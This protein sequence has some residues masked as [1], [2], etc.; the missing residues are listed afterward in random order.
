[1]K[2]FKIKEV[3]RK[4]L[5]E[6]NSSS[7]HSITISPSN[8]EKKDNINIEIK[9]GVITIPS[10]SHSFVSQKERYND[11]LTKIQYL[12]GIPNVC[13]NFKKIKKIKDVIKKFTGAKKVIFEWEQNYIKDYKK[14]TI[15][16]SVSILDYCPVVDF[17]GGYSSDDI[18]ESS[19]TIKEFIFNPNSWL[20][21]ASDGDSLKDE[22]FRIRLPEKEGINNSNSETIIRIDFKGKF[23]IMEFITEDIPSEDS[24]STIINRSAFDYLRYLYVDPNTREVLDNSYNKSKFEFLYLSSDYSIKP[25]LFIENNKYFLVFGDLEVNHKLLNSKWG[26]DN[27]ESNNNKIKIIKDSDPKKYILFEIELI[28][29]EFGKIL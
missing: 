22:F 25:N 11:A 27:E 17:C 5:P 21:I 8:I 20:F 26:I 19:T 16:D 15:D 9:D 4:G 13:P 3:T 6:T 1:M 24:I 10:R 12:A 23:G 2:R 29:K 18:L 7:S 14:E 28:S